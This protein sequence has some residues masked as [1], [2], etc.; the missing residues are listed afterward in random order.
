MP[1]LARAE[2]A[3]GARDDIVTGQAAGFVYEKDAG[4]YHLLSLRG[5]AAQR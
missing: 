5:T 1:D 4:R 2:C 3:A